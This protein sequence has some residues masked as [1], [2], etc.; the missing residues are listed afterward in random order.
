MARRFA[1]DSS[2]DRTAKPAS[3]SNSRMRPT[4]AACTAGSRLRVRTS[5]VVTRD[6]PERCASAVRATNAAGCGIVDATRPTMVHSGGASTDHEIDAAADGELRLLLEHATRCHQIPAH[7][8]RSRGQSRFRSCLPARCAR[9]AGG[10][11]VGR[12]APAGESVAGAAVETSGGLKRAS[13]NEKCGALSFVSITA[14]TKMHSPI[15]RH[16]IAENMESFSKTGRPDS[17]R[18]LTKRGSGTVMARVAK[19]LGGAREVD[20][21]ARASPLVRAAQTAAIIAE[22]YD[23]MSVTTVPALAPESEPEAFA[24]W[25]GRSA[26]CRCR[27]RVGHEP[28]LGMLVTWLLAGRMELA[29]RRSTRAARA[30][31]DRGNAGRDERDAHVVASAGSAGALARQ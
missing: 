3:S 2:L 6:S 30:A 29:R 14:A 1:S 31:R 19:G 20:R 10:G 17:E 4:R 12:R 21:R 25:L 18:P 23:A 26:M 24:A 11:N 5:S 8:P 27:G 7:P 22:E 13:E 28:H 9:R 16:A 15:V